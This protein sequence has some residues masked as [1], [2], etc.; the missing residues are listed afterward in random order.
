MIGKRIEIRRQQLGLSQ[1][2]LAHLIG[3]SPSRI[4]DFERGAKKDC[5]LSTAKRLAQALGVSIDYLAGT[6]DDAGAPASEAP[7]PAAPQ[8]ASALPARR[9]GRPRRPQLVAAVAP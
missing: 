6:W 3:I 7:A 5:N 9:R 8:G 4:S 1:T 2:D